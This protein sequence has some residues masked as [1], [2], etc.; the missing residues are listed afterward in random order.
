MV[1]GVPHPDREEAL[2]AH[3]TARLNRFGRQLLVMRIEL[4]RW[5]TATVAEVQGAS[6]TTSHRWIKRFRAEGWAG[7]EDRTWRPHRSLTL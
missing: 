3:R 1:W 6:R 4:D 7:L 2:I 5:P